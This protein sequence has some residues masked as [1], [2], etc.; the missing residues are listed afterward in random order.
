MKKCEILTF[1][2]AHNYGALLQCYALKQYLES[3]GMEVSVSNFVP[4]S[5]KNV[6]KLLPSISFI[7]PKNT[8]R[9]VIRFQMRK[10]QY[11][12]FQQFISNELKPNNCINPDVL[13]VGSDQIWNET[14]TGEITDYYGEK[15]NTVEKVSYA[16]SFGT[17]KLSEFQKEC[18]KKYL[19]KFIKVSIREECNIQEVNKILDREVD[20]VL[21][22]VFLF[23]RYFWD[24]FG[25]RPQSCKKESYILYY[26]LRIDDKLIRMAKELSKDLGCKVYAVHPTCIKNKSGFEQLY[27]VGPR[28]F[29]YLVKNALCVVTN[30]FHA[31]SFSQIFE[32]KVFYKSYSEE[33]SRVPTLLNYCGINYDK[34]NVKKYDFANCNEL[35]LDRKKK[36]SRNFLRDIS[37]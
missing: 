8:F 21:D 33:E 30:S 7:H 1:Q 18:I 25:L 23:D 17:N 3:L 37:R 13:I 10:K 4:D 36:Y 32:K 6:Y 31:V 28:E 16:G 9:E 12:I 2:F 14:I 27:D 20:C 11:Y 29:V 26:A 19:S 24:D 35:E 34:K 15:Y 5:V 22:P